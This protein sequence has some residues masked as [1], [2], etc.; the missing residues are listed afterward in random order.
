MFVCHSYDCQSPFPLIDNVM[1]LTTGS[2]AKHYSFLCLGAF[3]DI[4]LRFN[5]ILSFIFPLLDKVVSSMIMVFPPFA[6]V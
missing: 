1:K 5:I 3:K 6:H 2:S 4:M